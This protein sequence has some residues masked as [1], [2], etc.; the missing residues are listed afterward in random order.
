MML[1]RLPD[2]QDRDR[3]S[4]QPAQA[5]RVVQGKGSNV[6][7]SSKTEIL[8]ELAKINSFFFFVTVGQA[9]LA[10]LGPEEGPL[11]LACRVVPKVRE[12]IVWPIWQI[13]KKL[14]LF[15]QRSSA[16]HIGTALL[17][18]TFELVYRKFVAGRRRRHYGGQGGTLSQE[19]LRVC[20]KKISHIFEL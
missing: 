17:W 6:C 18:Q 12:T 7:F 2:H 15:P 5:V 16:A 11:V 10:R 3:H 20:L 13:K 14:T 19:E 1:I 9:G 4:P 8:R